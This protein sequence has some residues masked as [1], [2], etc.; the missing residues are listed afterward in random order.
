MQ[1]Q[2]I[3]FKN[4]THKYSIFVGSNAINLLSKKI[5]LLCPK[6]KKIA[7]IVDKNVPIKFQNILKKKLKNYNLIILPFTASEKTKS[8]NTVNLYLNK[9][10]SKNFNRSDLIISM[11]GGITGDV[12]GFISSIYKRGINFINIP[13]TLLA[14]VDSSIGGKTGVNSKQG[15]NLVGSFYQPKLVISDTS[16]LYSLSKKQMVCGYAEILK[17][18]I[19]KD[20]SFF[21]W[22]KKNTQNIFSKKPKE[23]IYAI[24]KSCQIKMYFVNKDVNEKGLRMMLN[25]GHTFAHAIEVKNNYSNK[26]THGEAVLSGIILATKLSL[27][28][29]ICN[30][31]ILE[32]IKQIYYN[33]NLSYTYKKY[34]NSNSIN[35]LIPYLKNDKKNNDENINFILLKK[36]G[37]TSLPNKNK[38]SIYNLK[39]LSKSIA[40][41]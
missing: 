21:K 39:K 23:L 6:T 9:L 7:L 32:E 40:Q 3:K 30:K 20:K 28:N 2:E 24:K 29:K 13:T 4:S 15:K 41:C 12:V 17:H 31:R 38:I 18:S 36:I 16:F 25:F 14:Q 1:N 8:L 26:I 19:I 11:G 35:K 33:N 5:K 37:K 27:I 34:T 10:L 22:L